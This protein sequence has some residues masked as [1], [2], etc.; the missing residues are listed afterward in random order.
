MMGL[1]GSVLR[2]KT[3]T[4]KL[5]NSNANATPAAKT[6]T[7]QGQIGPVGCFGNGAGRARRGRAGGGSASSER[8]L[9]AGASS[10]PIK[11]G[12]GCFGDGIVNIR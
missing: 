7:T 12:V 5:V 10:A 2:Q 11:M 9:D 1:V 4:A 3:S 8:G 6:P